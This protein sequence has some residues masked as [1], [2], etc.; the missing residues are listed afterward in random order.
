[1]SPLDPLFPGMPYRA[2]QKDAEIQ[3]VVNLLQSYVSFQQPIQFLLRL[4][5]LLSYLSIQL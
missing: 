4:D 5:N 2:E 3:E 1:M